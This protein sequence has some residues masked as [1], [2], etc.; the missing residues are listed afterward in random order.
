MSI[1]YIN[2]TTLSNS[3]AVFTD[4]ALTTCAADGF[5]SDGSGISRNQIGCVL[6]PIEICPTCTQPCDTGVLSV[7]TG[8]GT[9]LL[10]VD[11][12]GTASDVGAVIIKFI[13]ASVPDGIRATYNGTVYNTLSS[14]VDGLHTST[15]TGGY[16]YVGNAN[17]SCIPIAG[18]SYS[19]LPIYQYNGT[20]FIDTG[21][22][23]TITPQAGEFSFSSQA[24]GNLFMVI[25]KINATPTALQIEIAGVCSATA[26]AIEASCPALLTGYSSST[27]ASPNE[28]NACADS[29]VSTYYNAPVAGSPGVPEIFDFVFSDAN[30][31]SVL[32]NGF[33]KITGNQ[34]IQVE[35]GIIIN[36]ASC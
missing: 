13:P 2:G 29:V 22:I 11:L 21:Q 19:N 32:T 6:G 16:T 8:A 5:Y 33:Y 35:N 27:N 34:W 31:E 17:A 24:P 3:T 14:N 18:T 26:F 36:K 10:N 7:S 9:F 25:P 28:T 23:R 15:V 4:A 20:S 12:G 30:G 1:Y